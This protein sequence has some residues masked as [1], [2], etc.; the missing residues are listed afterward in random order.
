MF[1]SLKANSK[2]TF[3]TITSLWVASSLSNFILQ[4]SQTIGGQ[5]RVERALQGNVYRRSLPLSPLVSP[6]FFFFVNCSSPLYYL[7]AWN[8]LVSKKYVF[9]VLYAKFRIQK[10]FFLIEQKNCV[11]RVTYLA[12]NQL[13]VF[14]C[15]VTFQLGNF[16]YLA[17]VAVV[18]L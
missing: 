6:S 12:H 11:L 18:A 8:R 14:E 4:F 7:N 13:T 15:I 5:L 10:F 16:V 9:W 17:P 3:H 2:V 1:I